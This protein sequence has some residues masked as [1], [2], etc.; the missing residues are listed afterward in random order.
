MAM[1]IAVAM[2]QYYGYVYSCGYIWY[3]TMAMYI[4]VAMVQYYGYVYSCG[5]GTVL[6]LCI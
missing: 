1:Y 4:A 2:V 6:W 3:S 5:Y